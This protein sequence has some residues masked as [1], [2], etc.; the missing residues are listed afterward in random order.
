[1][2]QRRCVF[3][4]LIC[5]L[6]VLVPAL[7]AQT[8]QV[9]NTDGHTTTLTAAQIAALPH[10]TVT[11]SDHGTAATFEGVP[12][13]TLLG[14]AGVQLGDK[15]RGPR[16]T[17]VLL[18]EATDGYKVVFALAEL[19]P[20]FASGEIILADKRDGKPLDTKEGPFRVVVPGDERPA[21]WVRQVTTLKI[22]I[23][24]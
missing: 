3:V 13:A 14:M 7:L 24:K 8:L 9:I 19:N 16:M 21:R 15:L 5:S 1:M 2:L 22:V 10:L 18:V 20:A 11:G 4:A 23:V 17:E 6:L 12:L